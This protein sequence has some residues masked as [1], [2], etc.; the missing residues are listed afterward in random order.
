VSNQEFWELWQTGILQESLKNSCLISISG[1]STAEL[2]YKEKCITKIMEKTNGFFLE[3]NHDDAIAARVLDS[4]I[5]SDGV[6]RGVARPCGSILEGYYLFESIDVTAK[7]HEMSYEH[8]KRYMDQGICM[9]NGETNWG[10]ITDMGYLSEHIPHYDPSDLHSV[11]GMLDFIK[12]SYQQ[13][14]DTKCGAGLFAN[15]GAV[16]NEVWGPHLCN[17]HIWKKKIKKAF[18]PNTACDPM[19]YAWPE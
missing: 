7:S 14:F 5:L 9:D 10:V 1:T 19:G 12:T 4:A 15:M 11:T 16:T 2:E 18:D 13:Q 6:F 8:K 17:L 3:Q